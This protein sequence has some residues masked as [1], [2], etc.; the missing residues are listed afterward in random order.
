[1]GRGRAMAKQIRSGVRVPDFVGLTVLEAREAGLLAGVVVV[2]P[3]PDTGVLTDLRGSVVA[4][5]PE[6]GALVARQAQVMVWTSGS[7]GDA[8]VREPRN[9]YPPTLMNSDALRIDGYNRLDFD[10]A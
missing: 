6:A 10:T 9:P 2:G 3:D 5:R 8:G 7:G 1:M 4:Q